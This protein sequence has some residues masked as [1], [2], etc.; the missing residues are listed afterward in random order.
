MKKASLT[1]LLLGILILIFGFIYDMR[2]AGIPFQNPPIELYKQFENYSRVA[3]TICNLG[4]IVIF[5][6]SILITIFVIRKRLR[7]INNS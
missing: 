7:K 3:N 6:N 1:S 2:Y 4:L 5:T